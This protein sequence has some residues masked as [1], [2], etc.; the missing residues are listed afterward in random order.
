LGI[1]REFLG[2]GGELSKTRIS[3][4]LR[5]AACT[6]VRERLQIDLREQLIADGIEAKNFV[7]GVN[8]T[9]VTTKTVV[10]LKEH[11]CAIPQVCEL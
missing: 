4:K 8:V 1:D 3:D 10:L 7:I 9:P 2:F 11:D 6:F 5:R